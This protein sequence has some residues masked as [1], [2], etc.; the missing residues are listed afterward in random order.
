M[1]AVSLLHNS[2]ASPD[3]NPIENLWNILKIRVSDKQPRNLKS[4]IKTIQEEWNRLPIEL[5]SNLV[6]SMVARVAAVI[7]QNGDYTMY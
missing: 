6:D 1:L 3:L 2:P 4:L 7:Q 5:A